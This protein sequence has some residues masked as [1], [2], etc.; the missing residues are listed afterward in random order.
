[1]KNK[2]LS[3]LAIVASGAMLLAGCNKDND[4]LREYQRQAIQAKLEQMTPAEADA[5][6]KKAMRGIVS[7]TYIDTSTTQVIC[8]NG[9]N[10]ARKYRHEDRIEEDLLLDL[11]AK[12]D[13]NGTLID[14]YVDYAM[15]FD[16]IEKA[17]KAKAKAEFKQLSNLEEL[18]K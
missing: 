11:W 14:E 8:R 10:L 3:K 17:T 4:A 1:M 7:R 5:Y 2:K 18:I 6:I 16:I 9:D 15:D 13:T 12:N